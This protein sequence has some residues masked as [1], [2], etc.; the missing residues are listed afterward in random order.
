MDP[1][2]NEQF[3]AGSA[4]GFDNVYGLR[5]L[6]N[7]YGS[8]AEPCTFMSPP[9]VFPPVPAFAYSAFA[10]VSINLNVGHDAGIPWPAF[11]PPGP[12]SPI[13]PAR[14]HAGMTSPSCDVECSV[15][16]QC[17]RSSL[18][19]PSQAPLMSYPIQPTAARSVAGLFVNGGFP[20]PC[21][22]SP[23]K[24]RN[25]VEISLSNASRNDFEAQFGIGAH[26]VNF[27]YVRICLVRI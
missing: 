24:V 3:R 10:P 21:P 22:V 23:V 5:M 15:L 13:S 8:M 9:A 2:Y 4:E 17:N 27:G 14:Y 19:S 16:G 20:T 12:M 1:L 11:F 26:L 6:A 18:S 25:S 7:P